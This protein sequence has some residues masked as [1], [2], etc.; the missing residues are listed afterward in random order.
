VL[1]AE[2]SAFEDEKERLL[3]DLANAE[4]ELHRKLSAIGNI[5]DAST[6][7]ERDKVCDQ[8]KSACATCIPGSGS[9]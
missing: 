3:E 9:H 6:P 5:V 4:D 1:I 2:K 8:W 7:S